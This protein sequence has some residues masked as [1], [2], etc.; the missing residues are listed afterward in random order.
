MATSDNGLRV[1]GMKYGTKTDPELKIRRYVKAVSPEEAIEKYCADF[2]PA[3][4]EAVLMPVG[5]KAHCWEPDGKQRS[6]LLF[7]FRFPTK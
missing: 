1:Y 4:I 3:Q 5:F 7:S 6:A 2:K